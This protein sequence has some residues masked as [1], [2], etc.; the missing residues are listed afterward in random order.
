MNVVTATGSLY[1]VLASEPIVDATR[2]QDP[3]QPGTTATFTIETMDND[4]EVLLLH[5]TRLLE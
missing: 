4:V 1:D 3:P 5:R 2:T